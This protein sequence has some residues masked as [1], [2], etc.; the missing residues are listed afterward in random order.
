MSRYK[1]QPKK[2]C[3]TDRISLQDV[4]AKKGIT[5]DLVGVNDGK[6]I[7]ILDIHGIIEKTSCK[8]T[9]GIIEESDSEV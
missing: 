3:D 2:I 9:W 6:P 1:F 7:D 4:E 8:Q 5:L